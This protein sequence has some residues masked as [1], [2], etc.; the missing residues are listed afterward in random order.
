MT[1]RIPRGAWSRAFSR[2]LNSIAKTAARA[3]SKVIAKTLQNAAPASKRKSAKSKPPSKAGWSSGAAVGSAS[4]RRYRL[5]KPAGVRHTERLPLIVML[6][7][8]GQDA[9]ALAASTRMNRIAASKRFLVLYP[10]QERI[11][12]VQGCWNWFDTR[13]GRAQ[14]E[15]DSINAAI[16]Q[17]C[18][19]HPVDQDRIALAGLS[20]GA[21]M[22]ALTAIRRPG[23]FQALAMHSGVA[24]G[25]A[26]SSATAFAAMC[27]RKQAAASLPLGIQLPALLVIHGSRDQVVAPVNG[28]VT[29]RQ[30][31]AHWGAR[32]GAARHVRRGER[33]PAT[34][35]DYRMKGRIVATFCEVEGLGH[36]W[37]GGAAGHAYSDMKGPNASSMIWTFASKQFNSLA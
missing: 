34:I 19:L 23:R 3:G 7:G 5:Y 18:L 20:A 13:H 4:V 2:A 29:A 31:A 10:E 22:A 35:I 14:R 16:D 21:S 17:V 26:H 8:C 15:A 24:T 1:R 9:A 27:G 11:S 36:A 33:Y 30:W 37:S 25:V 32:P 28:A 12:N 6:H